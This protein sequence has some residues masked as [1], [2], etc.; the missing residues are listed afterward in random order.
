MNERSF[1]RMARSTAVLAALAL[2][3]CDSDTSPGEGGGD[4]TE[5][6]YAIASSVFG[7][8]GA[9]T[10]VS[11]LGSVDVQSIDIT[12]AS[13]HPQFATI[14]AVD[15][16][17]FVGDGVAPVITRYAVDDAGGLKSEGSLSF[18]PRGLQTSPLYFNTF[19]SAD[20]AYLQHEQ[21]KRVLWNPKT[22]E[23]LGSAAVATEGLDATRN[24]LRVV[25]A[26]D[27]GIAVRDGYVFHAYHWTDDVYYSFAPSSQIAV[28]SA[29]DHSL[30][31]LLDAPCPGLDFV[32]SD[33]EGN[34]YFSNWVFSAAAPV[35]DP[36]TAPA[37]CVVRIKKGE[38]AVDEDWSLDLGEMVGGRQ[39][40]A[41]RYLGDSIGIVAVFHD[42][43]VE[44]DDETPATVVTLG[45]NWKLWRL[46]IDTGAAEPVGGLDWMAGGYY[47]FQI[48]GRTLLLLPSADYAKTTVYELT[49][50][51]TAE[52]LYETPGW[53]YQFVKI[54]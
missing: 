51:G 11:I 54:R 35:L 24:G 50:D 18:G 33:E 20:A 5:P 49:A 19:V 10:Y 15:G 28:F 2:A 7:D 14:A 17:L 12:K 42:E 16:K 40:A 6:A 30:V 41:F 29:E 9:S 26:Y 31:D 13:E 36:D 44:I 23:L 46:N 22:M 39:T 52:A 4:G 47:A 8:A 1:R 37:T 43:N 21:N 38:L 27:R 45:S 48:D 34:L 53:A 32:T 25:S 3:A